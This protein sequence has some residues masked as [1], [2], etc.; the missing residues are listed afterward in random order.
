MLLGLNQFIDQ[1]S[2]VQHTFVKRH[3]QNI[4][5][6]RHENRKCFLNNF[7]STLT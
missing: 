5:P 4:R 7:T 3:L 2:C 1:L 6:E